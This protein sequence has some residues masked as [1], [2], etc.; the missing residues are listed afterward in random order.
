M[1]SYCENKI[2]C[3]SKALSAQC[4]NNET[5]CWEIW[6]AHGLAVFSVPA[7]PGKLRKS[8]LPGQI[9]LS[10]FLAWNVPSSVVW[11]LLCKQLVQSYHINERGCAVHSLWHHNHQAASLQAVVCK[12][13]K[14]RTRGGWSSIAS[15]HKIIKMFSQMK[16][17]LREGQGEAIYEIGV[18]DNGLMTGMW[19]MEY[20]MELP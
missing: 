9:S 2:F 10:A 8:D 20:S 14:N 13:V 3:H 12:W 15:F 16:W 5:W 6:N 17:R 11:L 4:V 7:I 19:I 18:E 1:V